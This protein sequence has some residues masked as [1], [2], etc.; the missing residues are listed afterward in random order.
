MCMW[1]SAALAGALTLAGSVPDELGTGVWARPAPG[2]N[3]PEAVNAAAPAKKV[4]RP[5]GPS[6][7]TPLP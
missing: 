6:F 2:R 1:Q 5:M 4:R 3:A 7:M